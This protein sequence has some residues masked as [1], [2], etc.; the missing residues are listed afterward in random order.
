MRNNQTRLSAQN[1]EE[2]QTVPAMATKFVS[3]TEIVTLP[4]QGLF[5]PKTS[6][7]YG[8]KSVEIKHMTTA[9]E[10]I[11]SNS[12]YIKNDVVLQKFL[13][14][15]LVDRSIDVNDFILCDFEAVL[16][17]ARITGYGPQYSTNI[18]CPS[19]ETTK[20]YTFSAEKF[21]EVASFPTDIEELTDDGTFIV[22][23]YNHKTDKETQV[24]CRI[25]TTGDLKELRE[26]RQQKVDRK[27]PETNKSD[28]LC[29]IIVSVDGSR[30]EMDITNF[31]ATSRPLDTR[32]I[33][34][35]YKELEPKMNNRAPFKCKNCEYSQ[36][37][38]VP[39]T[40]K[41]FW[42]Y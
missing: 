21:T 3:P 30:N 26:R 23:I 38:E 5:Y 40:V 20:E 10:D 7:L 33:R 36:E 39:M 41:F 37:I 19:C 4:S 24:E 8:R 9:E 34:A 31:V 42:P 12:S 25:L 22:N 35:K 28:E 1:R 14:S 11:L 15:V 29:S 6:S 17:A 27:L 13:Q 32:F 16:T 2:V 18:T